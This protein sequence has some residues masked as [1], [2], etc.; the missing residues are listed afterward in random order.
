M[1]DMN[2]AISDL[3]AAG[4]TRK[5]IK[6]A[7]GVT[8]EDIQNVLGKSTRGRKPKKQAK[9]KESTDVVILD[10]IICAFRL[11]VVTSFPT[12]CFVKRCV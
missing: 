8:T 11:E 12:I 9:T 4:W 2:K 1:A 3:N 5:D 7:L 6:A 10:A